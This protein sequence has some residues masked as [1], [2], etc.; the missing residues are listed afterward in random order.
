ML[1]HELA[2]RLHVDDDKRTPQFFAEAAAALQD[3]TSWGH[4][5]SRVTRVVARG[6]E[7]VSETQKW[8]RIAD[9]ARQV[10]YKRADKAR[11]S[12]LTFDLNSDAFWR[13]N[14][15]ATARM[16]TG[17]MSQSYAVIEAVGLRDSLD[18]DLPFSEEQ[19]ARY[20]SEIERLQR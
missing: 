6:V 9:K 12:G 3:E 11:S 8:A 5:P 14:H 1:K 16:A 2:L 10:A 7:A 20:K 19:M 13:F 18:T 4:L 17:R 15:R